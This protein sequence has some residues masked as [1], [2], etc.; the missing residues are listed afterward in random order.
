MK[1]VKC[2]K[3]S[4]IFDDALSSCI[5]YC[6]CGLT[7]YYDSVAKKLRKVKAKKYDGKYAGTMI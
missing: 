1:Q 3:C 2:K 4:R 7:Y 6:G 5:I